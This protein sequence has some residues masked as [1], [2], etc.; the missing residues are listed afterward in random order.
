MYFITFSVQ[1]CFLTYIHYILVKQAFGATADPFAAT[2]APVLSG[3]SSFPG[4][5]NRTNSANNGADEFSDF[6][7]SGPTLTTTVSSGETGSGGGMMNGGTA[8]A[9]GGI[10]NPKWRDVS[11]LV[12]L[13]GLSSNTDK[14]VGIRKVLGVLLLRIGGIMAR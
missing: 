14:K 5:M 3:G 10:T 7:S 2:P 11:S 12:D 4:L 1:N 8:S 9:P 6:Q 13:G